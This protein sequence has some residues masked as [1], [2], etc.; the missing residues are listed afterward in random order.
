[1]DIRDQP[2]RL[3]RVVAVRSDKTEVVLATHLN[4]ERAEAVAAALRDSDA[5]SEIRAEPQEPAS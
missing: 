4:R 1:M 2:G 5:F 3:Y